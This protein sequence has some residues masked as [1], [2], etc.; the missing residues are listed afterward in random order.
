VPREAQQR[1]LL[2][3]AQIR[4]PSRRP[5]EAAAGQAE[6]A[7]KLAPGRVVEPALARVERGRRQDPLHLRPAR[8]VLGAPPEA[9]C[10]RPLVEQLRHAVAV[11]LIR[12]PLPVG[13]AALRPADA[14]R[15]HQLAEAF[16]RP[17]VG[18][19]GL[20]EQRPEITQFVAGHAVHR[21]HAGDDGGGDGEGDGD[22]AEADGGRAGVPNCGNAA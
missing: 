20:A 14:E 11:A 8:D 17:G 2:A 9:D 4:R 19:G 3:K 22:G 6:L 10:A 15:L 7:A 1:G 13:P 5:P 18:A 12:L 16:E 21:Q